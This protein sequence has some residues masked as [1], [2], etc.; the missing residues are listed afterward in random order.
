DVP[1]A[2]DFDGDGRADIAVWRGAE[3]NWYVLRSSDGKVQT[4][5]LSAVG[6]D[7]TPVA[8]DF[9]GDG[10]ADVALWRE[11]DGRWTIESSRDNSVRVRIHGQTGDHPVA[12]G[13]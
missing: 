6:S 3:M 1:V 4:I 2:A 10:K 7:E 9:D 5:S 8:G 13:R 12:I 11:K